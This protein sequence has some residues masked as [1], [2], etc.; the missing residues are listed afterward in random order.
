[1][2]LW[3]DFLMSGGNHNENVKKTM[4]NP[5]NYFQKIK[6]TLEEPNDEN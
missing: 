4:A 1:M 5:I 3:A 6:Q 2:E